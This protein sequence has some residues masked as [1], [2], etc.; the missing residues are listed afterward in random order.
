MHPYEKEEMLF[1][2]LRSTLD[3]IIKENEITYCQI[4]G[5]I[6]CLK[7]Q[8]INEFFNP[9]DDNDDELGY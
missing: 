9:E 5:V 7:N 3:R 1:E 6:D 8:Y 4:I 2:E